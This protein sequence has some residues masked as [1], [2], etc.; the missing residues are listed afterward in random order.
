MKIE[1]KIEK[2]ETNRISGDYSSSQEDC[3]IRIVCKAPRKSNFWI[4]SG[5]CHFTYY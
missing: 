3:S 1:T 5:G 2:M 4:K